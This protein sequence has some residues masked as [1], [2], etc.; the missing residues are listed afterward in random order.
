M[1]DDTEIVLPVLLLGWC[2]VTEKG[3]DRLLAIH[4]NAARTCTRHSRKV[5][6][7]ST[8]ASWK[9]GQFVLGKDNNVHRLQPR[10]RRRRRRLSRDL[11]PRLS[12][13]HMA[14][15]SFR[16]WQCNRRQR[17]TGN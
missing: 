5:S 13:L 15:D 14:P 6:I 8:L 16:S 11:R 4:A 12:R 3:G 2:G 9:G 17:R 10:S 7:V 1:N